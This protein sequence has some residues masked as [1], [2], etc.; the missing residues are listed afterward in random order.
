MLRKCK[1]KK[2]NTQR[3]QKEVEGDGIITLTTM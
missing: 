1:E 3:K 2:K